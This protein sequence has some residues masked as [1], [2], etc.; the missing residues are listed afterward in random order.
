MMWEDMDIVLTYRTN[1]YELYVH[2]YMY[3]A[4]NKVK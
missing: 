2:I 4:L 1:I 3:C